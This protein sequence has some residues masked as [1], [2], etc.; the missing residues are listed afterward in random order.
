VNRQGVRN[1]CKM[2]PPHARII[3]IVSRQ[4]AQGR[5]FSDLQHPEA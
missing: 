1:C 5:F 4:R 2:G 3:L